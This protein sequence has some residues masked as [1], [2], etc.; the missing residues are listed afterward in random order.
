MQQS[1][2]AARIA[3]MAAFVAVAERASFTQAAARL[4]RDAT[5][6]SRRI[7][8]LERRLGVRLLERTTRRV[9]LTE[10]GTLFLERARAILRALDEAE[11]AATAQAGAEPAGTLRLALPGTFGRMWVAPLLPEFLQAHPQVRIEAEFSNRFVDLVGEGFDVAVR[12]GELPD[13]TLIARQVATR[14]RLICAAPAF[15]ARH[16]VPQRPQDLE[17][18]DCLGF[19]GFVGYP[20]WHFADANGKRVSVRVSGRLVADDVEAVVAAAV[21]GIGVMMSTDWLIG[22]ELAQGTLVPILQ[23]W[24]LEDEGAIHL[25]TPSARLLPSK[26]RAFIDWLSAR[27]TPEPPWRASNTSAQPASPV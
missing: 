3:E 13:S 5:V 2:E 1:T 21:H 4:G 7:H 19:R 25:V 8:A 6:L 11:E 26:T 15:L 12:L 16:G 17:A 10:A 24:S 18:T 22:R 27:F 20:D 14:R 9:A 23:D